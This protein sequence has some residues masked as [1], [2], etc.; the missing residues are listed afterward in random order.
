MDV[1]PVT[2]IVSTVVAVVVFLG[3]VVVYIRG[4]AD[5]GT[6]LTLEKNNQALTDWSKTLEAKVQLLEARVGML[7]QENADLRLQRPSAEAIAEIRDLV[8]NG[9]A[10]LAVHDA[11]TMALLRKVKP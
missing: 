4:S 6:I 5:K 9:S 3:G 7:E 1:L 10:L 8:E 2:M 11:Q